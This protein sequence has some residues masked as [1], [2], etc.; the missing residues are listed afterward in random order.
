MMVDLTDGSRETEEGVRA[1]LEEN[2]YTFPV[3]LDTGYDGAVS[4]GV[5]SIPMTILVDARGNILGGQ[6]G[7][8]AESALLSAVA[9]MAGE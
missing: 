4:Y 2:G 6:I 5:S 3:Y 1:F 9:D 7:A 8:V